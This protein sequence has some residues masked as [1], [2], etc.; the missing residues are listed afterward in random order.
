MEDSLNNRVLV[1]KELNAIKSDNYPLNR[2]IQKKMQ[3]FWKMLLEQSFISREKYE[4]L[5]RKDE[6]LP[7]ELAGFIERQ[8]VETRQSTKA[9][10][11]ILKDT[12][13]ESDIVYVK[14]RTVSQFRQDYKFVKVREMNDY[15]HAKDAYLNIV[16]GNT[17]FV[18]FTK[19]AARY[20]KDNP[21]RTYNL[22]KMFTSKYDVTRNGETAW[23]AG[24]GQ[25]PIKGSDDRLQNIDKYG[26]YN[27][28]TGAYFML[29]KSKDK[30]G[31]EIKTL[32]Y[33]P[34]YLKNQIESN[35]STALEYLRKEKGM[36]EPQILIRKIKTDTLFNV[37]GFH[38][39]L[40]GRTGKQLIFK[41][42]NQLVL[43]QNE[44]NTLKK[45]L[46]YTKRQK[47][48]KN[49][50][51]TK[52]DALTEQSLTELYDTFLYKIKNTV[53]HVRLSAQAKTLENGRETFVKLTNEEKCLVLE[54]IL[55]MFQC[56]SGAANLKLINGPSSAGILVMNN[57]I[58]GCKK[59][60]IIHQS[61]TGVFE[62]EIDLLA[63]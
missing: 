2:D 39:W 21:G 51:L 30:K 12:L 55:H 23:K 34:L 27:K 50:I 9:V 58:T 54:E 29:V 44:K 36:T 38:M 22:Q 48:N 24:K 7:N 33:I 56:Q 62:N 18:K 49:V 31:K 43:S 32:E 35:E 63:L 46:K 61:V 10:A 45:I 57:N 20:V 25:V 59:I 11:E 52:N 28:A 17:Y 16:V 3:P 1:K 14:A 41:G 6:F 37:D 47:E 53:Y 40:S 42:A 8:I 4:R 26:G 15:H 5:I 13:P 60:T 19:D